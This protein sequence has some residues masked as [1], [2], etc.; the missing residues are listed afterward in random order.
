M[1]SVRWRTAVGRGG[2]ADADTRDGGHSRKSVG[3]RAIRWRT[4]MMAF[5]VYVSLLI[6]SL[7]LSITPGPNNPLLA[8]AG[9]AYGF[10]RTLPALFGTLAGLAVLFVISGAGVGAIVLEI[11][12][13]SCRERVCQ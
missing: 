5:S 9:L 1:R 11:G 3:C 4:A 7:V 10:R 8:T 13:A 6:F 2:A 12:R